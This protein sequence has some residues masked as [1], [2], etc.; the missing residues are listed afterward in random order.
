[1]LVR[2]SRP[3]L[4]LSAGLLMSAVAATALAADP[5]DTLRA[6]PESNPPG[7]VMAHGLP[8]SK[9]TGGVPI[10]PST[11]AVKGAQELMARVV[12]DLTTT[13]KHDD[14]LK[15]L[16]PAD[17]D[18]LAKGPADWSDV[19][20]AAA[21]FASAWQ[22]QF[23]TS[24]SVTD[25]VPITFTEPTM[26]VVGTT[27]PSGATTQSAGESAEVTLTGP[28]RHQ[29]V[30][31]HLNHP[32]GG[33]GGGG[34]A[35]QLQL[36]AATTAADLHA[37]VLKQLQQLTAEQKSWPTDVDQAYVFVSQRVLTP[38]GEPTQPR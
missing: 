17:R 32:G 36:P 24:F 34:G 38:L 5:P 1:M 14:L 27:A 33:G 12:T 8:T 26:H 22:A 30:K 21:A 11:P 3:R 28:S 23:G 31:L 19:D 25:K 13:G 7:A 6:S 18:R 35:W 9:P 4:G 16:A 2:P 20:R 29:A 15:Q 10:T 37:A